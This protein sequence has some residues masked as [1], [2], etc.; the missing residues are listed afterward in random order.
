MP[1]YGEA[2]PLLE[3]VWLCERPRRAG[4]LT[5]AA[6]SAV[7]GFWSAVKG[8]FGIG[9]NATEGEERAVSLID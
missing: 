4:L 7:V 9:Q 3:H 1:L 8:Q 2:P 6:T 5:L